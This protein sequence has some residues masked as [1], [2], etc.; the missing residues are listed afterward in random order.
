MLHSTGLSPSLVAERLFR[1]SYSQSFAKFSFS[2][3][4]VA[5][6]R[7]LS[8]FRTPYLLPRRCSALQQFYNSAKEAFANANAGLSD[9]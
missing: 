6:A 8:F 2:H 7:T 4:T 9:T 1:H 3:V 5:R